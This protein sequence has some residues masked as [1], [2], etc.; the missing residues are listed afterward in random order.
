MVNNIGKFKKITALIVL[1]FVFI[2][3]AVP[4]PEAYTKA[5]QA[6]QN[7]DNK[8]AETLFLQ[9]INQK[10]DDFYTANAFFWL[11]MTYF[12]QKKFEDALMQFEAVRTC[13]NIWKHPDAM[14]KAGIC[15][16]NLGRN[17]EAK[18]T[19]QRIIVLFPEEKEKVQEAKNRS[20]DIK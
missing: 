1:L 11:G 13:Q 5:Y 7:N 15:Y 2:L 18:A 16:Q 10:P 8:K 6:Y 12:K 19:Y 20:A 17:E 9:F 14:M 4:E 3:N